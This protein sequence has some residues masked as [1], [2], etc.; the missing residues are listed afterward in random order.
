MVWHTLNKILDILLIETGQPDQSQIPTTFNKIKPNLKPIKVTGFQHIQILPEHN[1]W[2]SRGEN[3]FIDETWTLKS[4][5]AYINKQIIH[6][7]IQIQ[8][9][10]HIKMDQVPLGLHVFHND[11]N[12]I[13]DDVIEEIEK[14]YR[15]DIDVPRGKEGKDNIIFLRDKNGHNPT[16]KESIAIMTS[17]N[18]THIQTLIETYAN[19][20]KT[21]FHASDEEIENSSMS[22]VRYSSPNYEGIRPHIDNFNSTDEDN[23]S[24]RLRDYLGP[25]ITIPLQIGPKYLDLFPITEGKPYIRLETNKGDITIMDGQVRLEYAHSVPKSNE[26]RHSLCFKFKQFEKKCYYGDKSV[27][28]NT[29][30]IYSIPPSE[31]ERKIIEIPEE[32][33]TPLTTMTQR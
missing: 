7:K 32:T 31:K 14:I 2:F 1:T 33:A 11:T 3:K 21:I 18:L 22:I 17:E 29:E 19:A 9:T 26:T 25:L 10:S 16:Y 28:L 27:I 4:R 13:T 24:G 6:G 12:C 5:I 30:I 15:E 20:L 8:T 23:N